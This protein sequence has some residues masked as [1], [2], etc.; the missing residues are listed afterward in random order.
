MKARSNCKRCGI[1]F[2]DNN[3]AVECIECDCLTLCEMCARDNV[4]CINK[5]ISEILSEKNIN[6]KK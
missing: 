2:E 3:E 1:E 6:S 5:K 4:C